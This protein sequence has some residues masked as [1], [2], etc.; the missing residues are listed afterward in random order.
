[1]LLPAALIGFAA[2]GLRRRHKR[3]LLSAWRWLIEDFLVGDRIWDG[4]IVMALFPIFAWNFAL[5]PI[6]HAFRWDATFT[7]WDGW[8]H[9]GRQAWEWLQPLLGF[10][11]VT[12]FLGCAYAA[13]FFVLYGAAAGGDVATI[14][15]Q[16]RR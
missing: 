8:L 15:D 3:P 9:F 16:R 6:L 14:L 13:W 5:F 7:A 1:M 2:A 4:L 10:P 12:A 11:L